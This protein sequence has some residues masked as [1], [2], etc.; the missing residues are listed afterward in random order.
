MKCPHCE[1]DDV[2]ISASPDLRL[3]SFV[4]VTVT[5]PH[6]AGVF[7]IPKGQS[8]SDKKQSKPS[9]NKKRTRVAVS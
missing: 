3:L 6:C 8:S 1:M 9:V 4:F 2:Q 7:A 5:C